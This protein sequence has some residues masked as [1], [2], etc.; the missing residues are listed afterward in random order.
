[1]K[2]LINNIYT[3]I[4]APNP[5]MED[6]REYMTVT[7]P[8]AYWKAKYSKFKYDGKKRFLTPKGRM[9]TGFLP[10]I[11]Q[12]I[13]KNYPDEEVE[14]F[15]NRPELPVF[16]DGIDTQIGD[17]KM[18][19]K[20]DHQYR[21]VK[22]FNNY[23]YFRGESIYFPRGIVDAATNA[24]KTVIMAGIQKN[25]VGDNSMLIIIHRKHIFTQMVEFFK[26]IYSEVGEIRQ[27]K[28][29]VKDITV[30]MIQ[31]LY[32]RIDS[33]DLRKKLNSF[34]VVAI[35]ESHR[36]GAKSYGEV[37]RH[38]N[39]GIRIGLSGTALD[40]SDIIKKMV[41]IGITGTR[42]D[43]IKKRELMDKKV[44]VDVEVHI[45]L[46]NP[47]FDSCPR[48]YEE[49]KKLSIYYSIERASIIWYNLKK[50]TLIAVETIEHGEALYKCFKRFEKDEPTD[51]FIE[52]THGEDEDQY[53]KVQAFKEGDIDVLISTSILK[54]GVNLPMVEH[55]WYAAGGKSA[56]G[57]KQWMGRA[58]RL[59]KGKD[60]AYF[61]DFFDV[62]PDNTII[63]HSKKRLKVY[64]KE[65]LKIVKHY[66]DND[67][68]S[69]VINYEKKAERRRD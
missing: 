35:D 13:D 9:A 28:Y 8:N 10:N 62:S 3:Y 54:E 17:F 47:I 41:A 48:S 19:G 27:G 45:Y 53:E 51:L 55:T 11:L 57:I 49:S 29:D 21:A 38:C 56:I 18:E 66:S 59:H 6:I 15:D 46:C 65:Q 33:M 1:M 40:S 23:I 30:A 61:Y 32:S 52:F 37:L 26:D 34:D 2:I 22:N 64:E 31:T 42:L 67:V 36:T 39:A 63:Q 16:K 5:I 50:N 25:L 24:G 58:E 68:K 43:S 20:Y 60:K 4:K 7:P 12:Y 44:S 14:I 69:N